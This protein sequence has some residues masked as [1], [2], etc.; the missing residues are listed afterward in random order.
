M[1]R[2]RVKLGEESFDQERSGR[3]G[4]SGG[5]TA[6]NIAVSPLAAGTVTKRGVRDK[7]S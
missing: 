5:I 1:V 7:G 4:W 2:E 6:E 3:G